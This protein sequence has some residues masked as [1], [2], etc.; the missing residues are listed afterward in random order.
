V[1]NLELDERALEAGQ[2][3]VLRLQAILPDGTVMQCG[4]GH[5]DAVPPRSFE[6]EFTPQ[7]KWLDVYVALAHESEAS[8]SVDLEGKGGGYTRYTRIVSKVRDANTYTNEHEVDFG[9][10]N[11]RILFGDERRDA[12][13]TIRIAQLVRSSTGAVVLRENHVPPTTQIRAN[14][15]LAK[16]FRAVLSAMAGRQRN[17][18]G[19]RR[20]RSAGKIDLEA[21]DIPRFWLLGTLN[22]FIPVIAHI[23]DSGTATP[24]EAYLALGQ[25]IGQLCTLSVERDPTAIPKFNY[26]EL[27]A[28]FE[29]M[30][31]LA[32]DLIN[33]AVAER[34]IEIKLQRTP[35][36]VHVGQA[37]SPE[38]MKL[39][40][41]LAVT[42]SA[43][44]S[45]T[46]VR[47]RLPKLMKIASHNQVAAILNSALN[48]ARLEVDYRP[49]GALPVKPGVTFFR[50]LRTPEFWPDIN[51]TGSFA[52]YH[53]M[54]P[55]TVSL[56][57]YAVETIP[58]R[59]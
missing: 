29:P 9:R 2:F 43:K 16:G 28:V 4:E 25:L 18:A 5:V 53:P 6:A 57:L 35:N 24:E 41:Y 40:F 20:Q 44:I 46:D 10:P 21:A 45:E 11:I 33:T 36:G 12:Y 48:G 31:G 26:L 1:S 56:A 38:V 15:Y 52:I 59:G 3:R 23:V 7:M 55:N 19:S 50:I 42:G 47:D 51:A 49:P 58:Q 54:D 34:C 13:D 22:T 27:G 8:G 37:P 17:L 39:E 14:G 30:F 32:L